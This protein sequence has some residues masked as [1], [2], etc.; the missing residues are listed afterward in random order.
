MDL[1]KMTPP[2]VDELLADLWE[3]EGKQHALAAA[4]YVRAHY[5]IGEKA[6]FV[7]AQG[8]REWPTSD[9]H[10]LAE[11]R[12][13]VEAGFE[14]KPWSSGDPA[15][16]VASYEE[17]IKELARISDEQ[18]VLGNEFRRR[19]GWSRFYLVTSSDGHIHDSMSCST[20]RPSTRYGWLPKVSGL[21]AADAV[22]EYGPLLCSVC[23]PGAPVE[24][25]VGRPPAAGQCL[26]GVPDGKTVVRQ[27]RRLYG[28]CPTCKVK[29]PVNGDGRV[30]KHKAKEV[31]AAEEPQGVGE[32][33][34][35]WVAVLA[36][37][38]R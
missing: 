24:W 27:Y 28:V 21:S 10:A 14:V 22:A 29:H 23:F 25:C 11:C 30:R 8:R 5:A 33:K 3:R 38:S 7:G 12:K 2:Q 19:G 32:V 15:K 4:V 20:C 37:G 18:Q 34:S 1:T 13:L 31:E 6:R 35:P 9:E 26:G 17:I 16:V 36:G